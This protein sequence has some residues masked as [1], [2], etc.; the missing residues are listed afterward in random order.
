M[1]VLEFRAFDPQIEV[2][3]MSKRLLCGIVVPYLLDQRIHAGLVERFERGT[4][5][6]QFRAAHRVRL[7]NMHSVDPGH[8]QLGH[9]TELR[10]SDDGL[11]GEFRVVDSSMGDHFLALAKEG[12]LRQWSIGFRSDSD[13]VDGNV[14]V[15]TKATIFETALVPEGAY[16]ESAA[17]MAV[18][19][20]PVSRR[21]ELLALLP[22]PL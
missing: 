6:H 14:T 17:V 15:R 13:R 18:R 12:S 1:G 20:R 8:L 4:F 2:R 22:P 3:S 16:G 7:L 5:T 11:Y 21:D 19:A 9:G 10:D